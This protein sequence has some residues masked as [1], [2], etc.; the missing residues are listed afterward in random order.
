M[1]NKNCKTV[2][3]LIL[4][5]PPFFFIAIISR[6]QQG[7]EK[8]ESS[9]TINI[10]LF[11]FKLSVQKWPPWTTAPG[12]SDNHP[13]DSCLLKQLTLATTVPLR[14]LSSAKRVGAV[15]EGGVLFLL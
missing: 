1:N 5:Y 4:C 3:V 13:L 11:I 15:V 9:K 10:F 8:Y 7:T 14:Q 6:K 12:D 2:I